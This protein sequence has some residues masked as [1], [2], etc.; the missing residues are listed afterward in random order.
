MIRPAG[1]KGRR[2]YSRPVDVEL[3]QLRAVV[4]VAEERSFT[5]AAQRL[6][7]SQQSVSA[8]IRRLERNLDV[9]LFDRT[10]RRASRPRRRARTCCPR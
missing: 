9:R 6:H 7:L 4:A 3:R 10:T 5:A 8:L 1:A 2:L